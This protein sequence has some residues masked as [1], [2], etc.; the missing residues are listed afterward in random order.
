MHEFCISQGSAMTFSGVVDKFYSMSNFFKIL[1][2]KNI[3][4]AYDLFLIGLFR[5]WKKD[6][7]V[8]IAY[9]I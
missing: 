3:K 7:F 6:A 1:C 4:M 5:K 9:I 2:M 8:V